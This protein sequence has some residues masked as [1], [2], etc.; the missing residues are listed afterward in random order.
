MGDDLLF[1]PLRLGGLALPNRVVMTTMKLGYASDGGT[2]NDRHVAF[3]VR[4]AEG[5]AGLLTSEP[6]YVSLAGREVVTQ[7]G[8][9]AEEALPGLRR[10]TGAVHDAGGRIMAHVNHAGRAAN[11]ELVAED[12]RISAS[13]V[14][15]PAN[16]VTPRPA[17]TEEIAGLVAAFGAA[18][19]RAREA[20]FDALE[21]PFSHGYLIH[22]F[23]SPWTNRRKDEY[24][25]PLDNRLRLGREVLA[26]ARSAVGAD[27]PIVVRMNGRDY[28]EGGLTEEDAVEVA[29]ALE[30]AG[31]NALSV[32]SGTMCESPEYC[33]Y[34]AGIPQANLLPV[35]ERVREAVAVPVIVAGRIREPEVAREALA[36]GQTDLIGLGRPFL[37]DPDWPLK[38]AGEKQGSILLCAGC[39]QGCVGELRRGI[40]TSCVFRPETGRESAAPA[41]KAP[42]P[43][44]VLVVGGGP[45]GLAA[46]RLLA[47][48]GHRVELL[49]QERELGGQLRLAS[50][51]PFKEGFRDAIRYMEE[52]ARDAGVAIRTETRASAEE[53]QERSPDHVVLATGSVPLT[54]YF[55]GLEDT[56]WLLAS[57]VLDGSATVETP[58][59][60]VIGGG[61]L[62]LQCSDY[63]ASQ[64]RK[65]TLVEM[66]ERVGAEMEPLPRA[67]VYERLR[68][69]GAEMHTGTRLTRFDDNDAV[70]RCGD[71]EIR[72]PVET[73]V[74]AVGAS[75]NRTLRRALAESDLDIHVIGDAVEPRTA[76]EAVREGFNLGRRL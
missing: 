58:T 66:L 40:G 68:Q 38:A 44:S 11:P 29:R 52:R 26:A 30:A 1:Q 7:L 10:L 19:G 24:G 61:M 22:Q 32:T 13:D 8:I 4:R 25:G 35:A 42:T 43:L 72:F 21:I 34:P 56:R 5:G 76:L 41:A 59:V 63:L 51:P 33:L 18:A 12:E 70:A 23:L 50:R 36:R 17:T 3:Y 75:P 14:P 74:I 54:L 37:C 73:V 55:P 46:A 39:H 60:L 53:I 69:H 65:I 67:M 28:V 49:E 71:R 20:G 2:V 6:M 16:G 45:A 64:G 62:G 9:C 48:R 15:C 47:E 57:E 31:A 27:F